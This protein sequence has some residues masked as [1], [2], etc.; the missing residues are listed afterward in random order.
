M[1]DAESIFNNANAACWGLPYNTYFK[2]WLPCDKNVAIVDV[3]CGGG[4]LLYF[5]KSR[6]YIN[7][8]GVDISPKQVVLA[9]QVTDG[10]VESDAVKFLEAHRERYD[11]I[12][13]LD[14]IEH[15]KKEEVFHFLDACYNALRPGGRII[16][17][18]PNA[19]SVFGMK[20][21]YGDF[22]HEVAFDPNSLKRLL[23][24]CGFTKIEGRETGPVV[25]GVI[26]LF[27]F[28]VWKIIRVALIFWNLVETGNA[29]SGIYTR[30]FLISGSKT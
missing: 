15:F 12:I 6:G 26:S 24:L 4:Q 27:R 5:F 7:I 21:R 16:L 28:L 18:T 20:I 13:G 11:L 19:E 10:V 14:I 8:S 30:V 22:T 2:R 9:R 23:D 25:H 29:G 17:Q 3:A 1:Q